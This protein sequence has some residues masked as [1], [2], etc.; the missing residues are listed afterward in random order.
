MNFGD[1]GIDI[2]HAETFNNAWDDI[3][4]NGNLI[5]DNSIFSSNTDIA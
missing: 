1:C 2:D 5:V 4:L 3:A